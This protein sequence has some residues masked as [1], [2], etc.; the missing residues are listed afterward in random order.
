MASKQD[1]IQLDNGAIWRFLNESFGTVFYF[2]NNSE[3]T[4]QVSFELTLENLCI[5]G[6]KRNARTFSLDIPPG[7]KGWKILKKINAAEGTSVGMQ[8]SY[9]F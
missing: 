8:Y 7:E 1:V 3:S 5:Q 4:L 9:S 2:E 6:E